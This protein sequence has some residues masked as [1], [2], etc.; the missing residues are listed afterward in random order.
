MMTTILL[1]APVAVPVLA[2]CGYAALGWRRGTAWLAP[3][4]AAG[5]LAAAV[6][7]AVLA[8]DRPR[9]GLGGLLRADALTALMLLVIG[10][11]ALPA[12]LAS[13]SYLAAERA[14][15][16]ATPADARRYGV[17]TQ[18]FIASMALAVLASSLGVLWV[19]VEATTIVTAFLVG[20]RRTRNAVE[21]AW[22]YVVIC[23]AGIA[24]ALLGIV[25][26]HFAARHAHVPSSGA[27]DWA[28]L[29]AHAASLDPDVTRIAVALLI[30][31][32]GAKAG[33]APLHA[34]LPDAHG[35]A[36]APVSALMS[37]VLLSVALYAVLR[38]KVIADVALGA[39]FARTLLLIVA[40]ASV[41]VA[42]ALLLA[43]RDLKRML[44]YS[45]IE[46]MGLLAL[47]TAI[48]TRLAMAAVLLHILGHGLAKAVSFL[49]AGRVQ[50]SLGTSRIDAVRAL[51]GRAPVLSFFLGAG[52]LALLGFPPFT[53]FATEVAM[54]RAGF[55][56]GLGWAVTAALV[57]TL[58]V[59]A[60]VSARMAGMLLGSRPDAPGAAALPATGSAATGLRPPRVLT[61][62]MGAGLAACALI[63]VTAWPLRPLLDAATDIVTGVSG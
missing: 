1:T 61:A 16:R 40:L 46:H 59:M 55:A 11:V 29:T 12:M 52:L 37:G 5:V 50:Q 13:P 42:A 32:F 43:Q 30:L 57:L 39:G 7:L 9:T 35:Q 31:G 14:A 21:A 53:L 25:L 34:W 62:A 28:R 15:G 63:G 6:C 44:A 33:L 26:L 22:K 58:V 24:L 18:G 41:A 23:S 3:A 51:G 2:A 19:A 20:H 47:G 48:G 60:A 56:T 4:A 36:P 49:A 38:V 54:V 45:S 8:A 17:L 10:A 27:L